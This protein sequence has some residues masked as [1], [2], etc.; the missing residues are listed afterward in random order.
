M[1]TPSF[2]QASTVF[3]DRDGSDWVITVKPPRPSK[4]LNLE[5][6]GDDATY[7]V[8]VDT[9]ILPSK[10]FNWSHSGETGK[11]ECPLSPA[12]TNGI[13]RCEV[14]ASLEPQDHYVLRVGAL[15]HKDED[16]GHLTHLYVSFTDEDG[17]HSPMGFMGLGG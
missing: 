9:P 2:S 15:G 4:K 8:T 16:L 13:R 7:I 6:L 11:H 10:G 5:F 3:V 12:G 14:L 1:A 17:Q